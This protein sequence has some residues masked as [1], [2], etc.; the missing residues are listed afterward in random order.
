MGKSKGTYTVLKRK[1]K[2]VISY[3]ED[4][5]ILYLD[6][7]EFD[8][9]DEAQKYLN[10]NKAEI[11]LCVAKI[12]EEE[13]KRIA[14]EEAARKAKEEEKKKKQEERAKK[15]AIRKEKSK[16]FFANGFVRFVSGFLAAVIA[17]VGGHYLAWLLRRGKTELPSKPEYSYEETYDP[18]DDEY[19]EPAIT[20]EATDEISNDISNIASKDES[21]S[22]ENFQNLVSDFAQEFVDN[23]VNIT[24][25]DLVKFVSIVNIE[26]LKEENP[27]LA[28]QLFG[29]QTKEV[30]LSDAGKVIG[31]TYTY[32]RNVFEKEQSTDNFI[33][34]S[35]SVY[36]EQKEKLQI[37]EG[38]VDKIAKV[39]YNAEEVNVLVSQLLNELGN[40]TSM[41]S[42]LDCGVGF[43][44]Q[45]SIEL[46]R[47]YLAKDT[48]NKENS[49][50]LT[51]FTSAEDYV[52]NIFTIYDGCLSSSKSLTKSK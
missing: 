23:K 25:E 35:D 47:S 20:Y 50:M 29:T 44:M 7:Y 17:L 9:L 21:L 8:D 15:R 38:Y 3:I 43:G 30:Y 5:K 41:I 10:N 28:S 32:N 37:I 40:P 45:V 18:S 48:L 14:E 49:D 36:G 19:L 39:R 13:E 16:V 33:R 27:E 42:Y 11:I 31:M 51:A 34:I 24:T 2:F 4:A 1:N 26:E 6:K 46:I 22:Q 12:K 52:S